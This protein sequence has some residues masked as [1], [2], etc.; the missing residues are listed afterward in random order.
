MFIPLS[1][2]ESTKHLE[3]QIFEAISLEDL[4]SMMRQY[5]LYLNIRSFADENLI[6][7]FSIFTNFSY[8]TR[9][10][11]QAEAIA[12]KRNKIKVVPDA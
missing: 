1:L 6:E 11:A 8:N 5:R 9:P 3:K 7:P 4:R 12:N 2:L 10:T